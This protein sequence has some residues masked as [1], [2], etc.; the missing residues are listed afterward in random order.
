MG[1]AMNH[2]VPD[3]FKLSFVILDI[4]ALWCSGLYN[5]YCVGADVKPCSINHSECHSARMWKITNDGLTWRGTGYF[6][7]VPVP[8]WQQ[9][10]SRGSNV[11]KCFVVCSGRL[12]V[13]CTVRVGFGSPRLCHYVVSVVLYPVSSHFT[14][15]S[16]AVLIG[17]LVLIRH[18]FI[19]PFSTYVPCL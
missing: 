8:I 9:W 16:T 17:W 10:P 1:T 19:F 13:R 5:L 15:S 6:I 3:R 11:I 18:V 12:S 7:A 2:P 4:Q 14:A